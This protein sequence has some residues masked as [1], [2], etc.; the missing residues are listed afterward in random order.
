M[1]AVVFTRRGGPDVL[2]VEERPDPVP[3]DGEVLIEVAAA[4]IS[5]SEV[6]A[7]VGLYPKAPEPPA[8]LGYDVAGTVA[9]TAER[10][11]AF[12]RH[13]GYAERAVAHADDVLSLPDELTFEEGAA[14]PLAFA[15]AYG[16]LAR[17]GGGQPGERVLVHGAAGGVGTAATALARELGLEVWGTASTG[18][19]DLLRELGVHHPLDY[20]A[21]GWD[22]RLPPFDIV[23][24]ALGGRSFAHSYRLLGAGGRLVCYGASNVLSGDRRNVLRAAATIA[25]TPRFNPMRLLKESRTVI[26]LDTIELWDRKGSLGELIRPLAPLVAEGRVKPK[27]AATFPLAEAPAA[28]RHLSERRQPG[29]VVL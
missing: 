18:K 28:H 13:G 10:V 3:G 7:R 23:M 2:R 21:Q 6:L 29:K 1:R 17:Y 14:I 11:A 16:A 24:D 5:Y 12:V 8:V 9:G 15:T 22:E 20:T 19:Q 27:V 26:G 25:R 4:G